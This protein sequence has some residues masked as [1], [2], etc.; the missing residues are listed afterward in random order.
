MFRLNGPYPKPRAK[1]VQSTDAL[2]VLVPEHMSM[3]AHVHACIHAC[4]GQRS[5]LGDSSL[6]LEL[7]D[8]LFGPQSRVSFL[9]LHPQHWECKHGLLRPAFS[10]GFR[11]DQTQVLTP[12]PK[13]S[14]FSFP[15]VA[16]WLQC[17]AGF[18]EFQSIFP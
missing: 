6:R 14:L 4:G 10:H 5:T 1:V 13:P 11:G 12:S 3:Q 15:T 17:Q 7:V 2:R 16:S 9:P 18:S 8:W